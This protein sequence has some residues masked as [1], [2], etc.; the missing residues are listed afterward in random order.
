MIPCTWQP[1]PQKRRRLTAAACFTGNMV[2]RL[3]KFCKKYHENKVLK[4]IEY[5]RYK[6]KNVEIGISTTS[7]Y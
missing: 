2:T 6:R 1:T 3:A 7:I 5:I 4:K